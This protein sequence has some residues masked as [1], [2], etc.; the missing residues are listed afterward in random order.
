MPVT[1]NAERIQATLAA[2]GRPEPDDI[3][4]P[5]TPPETLQD[6]PGDTTDSTGP[7]TPPGSTFAEHE[8][9]LKGFCDYLQKRITTAAID[10]YKDGAKAVDDLCSYMKGW[11]DMLL[12]KMPDATRQLGET[13]DKLAQHGLKLQHDPY[14]ATVQTVSPEGFPVSITLAKQD[15]GALISAL[16]ILTA[17]LREHGY[18]PMP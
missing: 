13:F 10:Q 5:E 1:S 6:G 7:T 18:T 14:T 15:T 8:A 11:A 4:E 12:A 2:E 17:W 3:P 16:P 9:L